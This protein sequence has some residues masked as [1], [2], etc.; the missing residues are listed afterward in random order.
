[1]S[2]VDLTSC[3]PSTVVFVVLSSLPFPVSTKVSSAHWGLSKQ[4]EILGA[5]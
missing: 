4:T 3:L 5:G 1:M 2:V